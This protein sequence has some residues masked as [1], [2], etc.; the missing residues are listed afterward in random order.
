MLNLVLTQNLS[1]IIKLHLMLFYLKM[2][3][4]KNFRN[5]LID[6]AIEEIR[7]YFPLDDLNNL[8][9]FEPSNLPT[10]IYGADEV[11]SIYNIH[12]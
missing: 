2:M 5:Q 10:N 7:N 6:K 12:S 8:N 9:I 1:M 3:K 11:K 4:F